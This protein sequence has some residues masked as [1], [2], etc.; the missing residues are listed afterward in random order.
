[1]A[2]IEAANGNGTDK[3]REIAPFRPDYLRAIEFDNQRWRLSVPEGV[4]PSHLEDGALWAVCG[5]KKL[6]SFDVVEVVGFGGRWWAEVL[7]AESQLGRTRLKLLR[8][9]EVEPAA[10]H[11][12]RDMPAG[13]DVLF[14]AQSQTFTGFRLKDMVP[15]TPKCSTPEAAYRQLVDHATLRRD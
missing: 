10:Q 5:A 11:Q 15:L 4:E 9:V 6:R 8:V 7:V 14:D 3:P 2:K 13:H 12:Q 1:M